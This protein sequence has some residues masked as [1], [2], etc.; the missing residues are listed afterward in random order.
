M[1]RKL[2]EKDIL[3]T[4]C[5]Q[6]TKRQA[7][8][9]SSLHTLC[10]EGKRESDD[11]SVYKSQIESLKRQI[12]QLNAYVKEMEA[13][14]E[15]IMTEAEMLREREKERSNYITTSGEK[16]KDKEEIIENT[17]SLLIS[18]TSLIELCN[19]KLNNKIP[20]M[21]SLLGM[22]SLYYY[23]FFHFFL[24]KKCFIDFYF[25]F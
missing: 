12:T 4:E 2:C 25:I 19:F 17:E 24:L 18:V 1:E 9:I 11:N 6:V 15:D 13:T 10:N 16:D 21:S 5:E 23:F 3:L 22:L 20:S 7:S 14:M 8:E